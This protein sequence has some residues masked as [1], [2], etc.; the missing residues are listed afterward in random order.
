V[1]AGWKK[2]RYWIEWLLLKAATAILPLLSRKACYH[3]AQFAG[4]LAA[5]LDQAGRRVALSNLK[6]AFGN[7]FSDA[8]RSKI[9]RESYQHFARTTL[10]LFWS[11]RLTS[12]NCSRYVEIENLDF[13]EE[14]MKPG[15]PIIFGCYHYSNFEWMSHAVGFR[16]LDSSIIAQEFKNP[17]LDPIFV[18]LR[19]T[20]GH[21]V[22][23]RVGAVLHLY[24]A[25]LRKGRVA[26]LVDLTIPT[27]LPTVAIE[28]FGLKTSVTFAHVWLHRRTGAPLINAHC[29]PLPDGRYRVVFHPKINFPPGASLQQMAQAC[30]DQF[31]PVVRRNPAP[32][33]WMYKHWRYRPVNA[34][35]ADYP[36]YA[37]VS[38]EFERRLAESGQET[39]PTLP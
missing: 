17:L 7:Q 6:V 35:P 28:C 37:N 13:W 32:W 5:R 23:P 11:P 25:V 33:L 30:W 22:V 1:R 9:T 38:V 15:Q 10:D 27:Q 14:E 19:E 20:A 3:L 12:E 26:I 21:R 34:E 8:Q 31:E 39:E 2:I 36:F 24:K 18:R 16:G 4:A 29:E